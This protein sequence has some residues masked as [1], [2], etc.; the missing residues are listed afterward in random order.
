MKKN[1]FF[2]LLTVTAFLI[3]IGGITLYKF[4][5]GIIKQDQKLAE[6]S[7]VYE[8]LEGLRIR[9]RSAIIHQRDYIITGNKSFYQKYKTSKTDVAME[10]SE[11]RKTRYDSFLDPPLI[12]SLI[13]LIDLKFVYLDSLIYIDSLNKSEK[14]DY[15]IENMSSQ[16]MDKITNLNK[17]L[18]GE[19]EL[20]TKEFRENTS[21]D[22]KVST[23]IIAGT[24]SIAVLLLSIILFNLWKQI[25]K[26]I[27]S[28]QKLLENQEKLKELNLV[29][30]KFFS[31]IAHDL[32]GPFNIMLNLSTMMDAAARNNDKDKLI[33]I[34]GMVETL[35]GK[36]YNLLNNLLEWARIQTGS[37]AFSP[38]E[39]CPEIMIHD[40]LDLLSPII[41][42]KGIRVI[43]DIQ[44]NIVI[45]DSNMINTTIRNI[46]TNAVKFTPDLGNIE[47]S[48]FVNETHAVFSVCDDGPG[49]TD[50]EFGLLFRSEVDTR[51]IGSGKGKGSGLGLIL[52]KEFIDRHKGTM[53]ANHSRLGGCCI[54]FKLPLSI[55]LTDNN[56]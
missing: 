56:I 24:Y 18:E 29:K 21:H 27:I 40:N 45:G 53:I 50:E 48:Y 17:G 28:E 20:L 33:E 11:F 25:S 13:D 36:T 46:L 15:I 12:D 38:I 14:V 26:R 10:I 1:Q 23:S 3:T 22:A 52:C 31:I 32:R 30:D 43:S 37:F 49:L 9:L 41:E 55:I 35:S 42:S 34:T 2:L 54:G 8:S 19:M 44:T 6:M 51:K 7:R 39:I 5:N 47:I 4:N 16:V